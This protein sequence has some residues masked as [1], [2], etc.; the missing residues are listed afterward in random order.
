M[1][2]QVRS[3]ADGSSD[4]LIG[5]NP[6]IHIDAAG[7]VTLPATPSF[8]AGQG[9]QTTIPD[10]TKTKISFGSEVRDVGGNYDPVLSRFVAPLTGLYLLSWAVGQGSNVAPSTK[11]TFAANIYKNGNLTIPTGQASAVVLD[12]SFQPSCGGAALVLLNAGDYVEVYG[13]TL[14]NTGPPLVTSYNGYFS[15]QYMSN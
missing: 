6:A 9:V 14:G 15:G 12:D 3:N 10:G 11:A 7:R 1:T 2:T 8:L 13:V 4:I 5:T